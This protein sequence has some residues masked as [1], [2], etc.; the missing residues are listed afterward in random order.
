MASASILR[1]RGLRF[2]FVLA[3]SLLLILTLGAAAFHFTRTQE[4]LLL[5]HL[6]QRAQAIGRLVALISP[7]SIYAFDIISLDRFAS[8][9]SEDGD[10]LFAQIRNHSNRPMTSFR[11]KG[12]SLGQVQGL[13]DN[14]DLAAQGLR[15]LRFPIVDQGDELGQVLVM[16]DYSRVHRLIRANLQEQLLIYVGIILFL[17]GLIFFIFHRYVLRPVSALLEGVNQVSQGNYGLR[18]AVRGKDELAELTACFN[19]MAGQILQ[20]HAQLSQ[21]N[22]DL[23][24]E[25]EQRRQAEAGLRLSASVFTSAREGITITKPDGSIID[26]NQAFSD[27]TGYSREEIIGQNPRLL[28]SGLHDEAF[29]RQM[30]TSLLQTGCWSGEIWN[31]HKNGELIAE[32]LTISTVHDAEGQV[33]HYV[34]L[35]SD[36]SAQKAHEA[37]LEHAAHYDVLTGLPNR[38]LLSDRLHQAMLQ[39]QRRQSILGLAYLDLDGFKEINDTYGHNVGD[40]LLHI[41]AERMRQCLR[42][43]DTIGRLGGD[44]FVALLM[45]LEQVEDCIPMLQRLLQVAAQPVELLEGCLQVSASIGV[46]FYPQVESVDEGQLMR[47]A[48]QAMY[49]AKLAGKNRYS[50][51]DPETEYSLRGQQ[52][53]LQ[54]L[55]RALQQGE[56][57]L[58]YQPKVNLRSGLLV[59]L[60]ALIRWNHPEQGLQSPASFLPYLEGH[61]LAIE[62]GEWVIDSALS[63]LEQWQGSGLDV[64]I[65]VNLDAYQLQGDGFPARLE[66][67]LRAHPGVSPRRLELELLET[68]TIKDIMQV[69]KLMKQCMELGVEFALDDFGTGYSSLIYLKHLPAR[70]LKIDQAFVRDMLDDTEDLAIVEGVLGLASAFQ[71]EIIAE[72]VETLAHG[73][74]LLQLGCE[75][76][77]GYGIARPMPAT[78]LPA[79]HQNWRPD[80][81]WQ[82]LRAVG[83]EHFSALVALVEHRAWIRAIDEFVHGKRSAPPVLNHHQCRFGQWLDRDGRSSLAKELQQ[84]QIDPLHLQVHEQALQVLEL[85]AKGRHLEV[86]EGVDELYRMGNEMAARINQMLM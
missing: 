85:H 72:G 56:F 86:L 3:I 79:W 36:I 31:R 18:L 53:S 34:A 23:A 52:E 57:E 61:P 13:I 11:P 78:E 39:T 48:D 63:Q 29:Y 58:Y 4:R 80:P 60:E 33:S 30:W 65:S 81:N 73:Q 1:S 46:S 59:G 68:S 20:D 82:R 17:A 47:Q 6:V 35:F 10:I 8:Q 27:I 42:E 77:Q 50:L 12:M 41:L 40:K 55:E 76:A 2:K 69:S 15:L 21:A 32:I 83:R 71:R 43:S 24:A 84:Q 7:P 22:K 49:Q 44:E 67:L 54:R 25:V 14:P 66:K 5:D 64:P 45:D 51:F 37:Q 9:A 74:L 19:R 16:L 75:L 28:H 62:L 38:V 70:I 26:V